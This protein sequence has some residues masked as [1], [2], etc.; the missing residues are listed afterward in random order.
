M[1]NVLHEANPAVLEDLDDT[2]NAILA[3]WSDGS[4]LSGEEELEA[5]DEAPDET[6]EAPHNIDE[7]DDDQEDEGSDEDPDEDTEDADEDETTEDDEDLE[8]VELSDE[9]LI[10]ITVDGDTKQAS[11]KDLKRLYGQEASLTRKSQ[12]V[13]TKR[14]EADDALNRADV[15]YRKLLERAE[16]RNKPY[17]EI[18][19]LV[20]SRQM[21]VEDFASLR[22]EAKEAGDDLS[23]L[24]EESQQFYSE[25]RKNHEAQQAA[26]AKEC[27]T[28]LQDKIPDWSND[29][30]NDIRQYAVSVGLPQ[31]QVDQYVDPSVIILLNKARMYD[32]T[33]AT[34]TTKKAKAMTV[35]TSKGKS[36]RSKKAPASISNGA[37]TRRQQSE[38]R[39]RDNRSNAGDMDDIAD[40]IMARWEQ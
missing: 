11:L 39:L 27:L 13:A 24:K 14:K 38:Q 9:S 28:T 15:S 5:K 36:L 4:D 12:E 10:E 21:S 3:N 35:K 17:S 31:E 8:E 1:T 18:D 20:A 23:F 34:A 16:A 22:R 6:D 2:A 26:S 37:T 30:Y 32:Q 25:A 19:M 33:K 7:D 29:L 40:A